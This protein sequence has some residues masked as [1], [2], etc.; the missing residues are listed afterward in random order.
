MFPWQPSATATPDTLWLFSEEGY[1]WA[2]CIIQW[3]EA[4]RTVVA[5]RLYAANLQHPALALSPNGPDMVDRSA[6]AGVGL[7]TGAAAGARTLDASSSC[8]PLLPEP[9]A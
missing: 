1:M 3:L 8:V 7:A 9:C 6:H 4:L 2:T 5:R